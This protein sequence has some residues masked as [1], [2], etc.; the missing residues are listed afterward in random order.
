M[1]PRRHQDDTKTFAELTFEEQAKAMSM[2]ALQFRQELH[3]HLRRADEEG[4][5]L[6]DVLNARLNLLRNILAFY[7]DQLKEPTSSVHVRTGSEPH[8]PPSNPAI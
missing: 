7:A 8:T 1:N 5:V 4:R 3:A 2:R 6:R